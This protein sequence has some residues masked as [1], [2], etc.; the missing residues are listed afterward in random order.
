M[1]SLP[2][3]TSPQLTEEKL[4]DGHVWIGNI[5]KIKLLQA[6]W[7]ETKPASF[8]VKMPHLAPKWKETEAKQ[9][10]TTGDIDYLC[11]RPMK[12]RI[13]PDSTSI[14]TS[15]YDRDARTPASVTIKKLL[16]GTWVDPSTSTN[17]KVA[18]TVSK[19]ISYSKITAQTPAEVSDKLEQ[20][21]HVYFT[22]EFTEVLTKMGIPY[23]KDWHMFM[24]WQGEVGKSDAKFIGSMG[25][26]FQVPHDRAVI[27]SVE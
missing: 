11:G 17:T 25:G 13:L 7:L 19:S 20:F 4:P 14:N 9:L 18:A 24:G 26:H 5:P 15:L 8:F 27:R 12:L 10:L 6:L 21:G 2:S 16:D 1:A 23:S 3:T 22:S